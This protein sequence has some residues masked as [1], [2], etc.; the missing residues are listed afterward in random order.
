M[1]IDKVT[2][3]RKK[4]VKSKLDIAKENEQKALPKFDRTYEEE[5]IKE[6][7]KED[8]KKTDSIESTIDV[9]E[10]NGPFVHKERPGE[11]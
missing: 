3:K 4:Q 5:L 11:E 10:Y 2:G 1:A 7:F 8:V 6:L 9:Q